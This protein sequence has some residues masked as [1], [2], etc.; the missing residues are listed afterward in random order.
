MVD[1]AQV[2]TPQL[3]RELRAMAKPSASVATVLEATALLLGVPDAH[4]ATSR[5]RMLQEGLSERLAG[6]DLEAVPGPQLRRARK[7]LCGPA[8][9][10]EVM[11]GKNPAAAP[12]AAWCRAA[13][14]SLAKVREAGAGAGGPPAPAEG[15]G[16]KQQPRAGAGAETEEAAGSA[17][18]SAEARVPAG[19]PSQ[20]VI[21][22]DLSRCSETELSQVHELVVSRP[23][24][25]TVVFHGT[26]DCRGLDI[27]AL[28]H[29]DI[30]EVCVYPDEAAKPPPGEG[31]N[32][33]AT[34]TMSQCWPPDGPA[35]LEDQRAHDRYR[36][37]IRQMTE[38]KAAKFVDYDCGAG[39]WTFQVERF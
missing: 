26:T 25:G 33:P 32:K 14:S 18:D 5:R 30:G 9:D 2:L 11:R 31:L 7:L 37:K 1:S 6:L 21:T 12:L 22:P 23:G 17:A 36:D 16:D 28:V 3:I 8:F 27:D 19:K 10:D 24:V 29:L 20:F 35:H 4:L 38:D 15:P 34:V 39:I 13:T